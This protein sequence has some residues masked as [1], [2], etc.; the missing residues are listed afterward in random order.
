MSFAGDPEQ[1]TEDQTWWQSRG[2]RYSGSADAGEVLLQVA[3]LQKGPHR[4]LDDRASEA[5]LGGK[6]LVI[7]LLEWLETPLQQSPQVGGIRI[8]G[9]VQGQGFDTR[10]D[11][12]R[13]GTGS[14][15]CMAELLAWPGF[16][17]RLGTNSPAT[18]GG[19]LNVGADNAGPLL[20]L[21][22]QLRTPAFAPA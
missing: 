14:A 21:D 11:H 18:V 5:I 19:N 7:D 3:A 13:K 10:G 20:T 17:P 1:R 12:D 22:L 9:A 8:A 4:A 16:Q 15:Q 6:P 2:T